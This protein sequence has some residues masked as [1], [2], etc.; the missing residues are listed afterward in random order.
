[1][2]NTCT[3]TTFTN[4]TM[5]AV[6]NPIRQ[7]E[8]D[9]TDPPSPNPKWLSVAGDGQQTRAAAEMEQITSLWNR[10]D[11]WLAW[12][13]MFLVSIALALEKMTFKV[14]STFATSDF[15][16]MSL[17]SAL[18]VVQAVMYTATMTIMAKFA[19][20][21]GR[22]ESFLLCV[23]LFTMGE[24]MLAASS[25]ISTYFAAHIF[26]V[27]GQVGIRFLQQVFAA[28]TSSLRNRLFFVVI[29]NFAYI[30]VPWCSAP[31]T[32]AIIKHST[33]KW[34]YGMWCIILPVVSVPVLVILFRLKRR[35]KV[36]NGKKYDKEK[37]KGSRWN[38]IKERLLEFDMIG[39]VLFTAG[40]SLLF[41]AVTLVKSQDSWKQAH[42]LSMIIIGPI[43][44]ILFPFWEMYPKYPFLPF[45]AMKNKTLITGCSFCLVYSIAQNLYNPY[46]FPWL[47]V[48]K[49]LSVTAA[50]NTS[51]TLM[52]A[53]VAS[54]VVAAFI[55]RYTNR[56]KPVI[57]AGICI[58]ML[59]LGLT[60]H[61]RQPDQSLAKFIVTQAVEG[62][63]QGFL[64][65]PSLVIIQASVPKNHVV[66]ATA[67]FYAANSIGQVIGDAISGSM[68]RQTYPKKLADYAPFL[69]ATEIDQMVNNVAAPLRYKWGTSE[70]TAVIEAFNHIYRKMLYGPMIVAAVCILIALALPNIDLSESEDGSECTIDEDE[71]VIVHKSSSKT[72]SAVIEKQL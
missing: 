29:P 49:G 10:T 11:F 14:Y 12:A 32:N 58:Y 50:S 42:V 38:F 13:S 33:W 25:N 35:V 60:Y 57:V 65:S 5:W 59:G 15:N 7:A 27:F 21:L 6:Q 72:A 4:N 40:L 16:E 39:L 48:C 69:N 31:I 68:Y 62:V 20:V 24:I 66:S 2:L 30:F 17:L 53:S 3:N 52:V 28:D 19:D 36:V 1:M 22:F 23:I 41:L 45:S 44:L 9:E 18:N 43:L 71:S 56:V 47:L 34:G 70:R 63:G 8:R 51:A 54:S 64:Q 37:Y 55:L 61:Y 46:Y 26:Y 67:I